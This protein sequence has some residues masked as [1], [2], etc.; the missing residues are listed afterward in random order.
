MENNSF[1]YL[2]KDIILYFH[3]EKHNENRNVD[4][5]E[6]LPFRTTSFNSFHLE[7]ENSI[8]I[9]TN[10]GIS[11]TKILPYSQIHYTVRICFHFL[12]RKLSQ[13][14]KYGCKMNFLTCISY[15]NV[16]KTCL[17][18]FDGPIS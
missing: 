1:E 17:P 2:T 6:N 13:G 12:G 15:Q 16:P 10:N 3:C 11:K 18:S 7:V 4:E 5:N 8:Y 14:T 9:F